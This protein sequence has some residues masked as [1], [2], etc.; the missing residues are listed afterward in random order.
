MITPSRRKVT[1]G[2]KEE[3]KKN[4]VKRGFF[5]LYG[6]PKGSARTSLRPISISVPKYGGPHAQP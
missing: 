4:A 2:E 1:Q 6:T 5:V 3:R